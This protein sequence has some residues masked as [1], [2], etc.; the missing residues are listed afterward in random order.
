MH[1]RGGAG[2]IVDAIDLDIER[3]G[4][5]VAHDLESL[6]AQQRF[7]IAAAAGVEIVD[8][9]HFAPAFEQPFAQM[10]ADKP[11]T[12]RYQYAVFQIRHLLNVPHTAN[13]Q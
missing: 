9:Q 6:R 4:D 7:D 1:R 3:E 10:R 5:V 8:A 11:R 2:E 12:P 13:R